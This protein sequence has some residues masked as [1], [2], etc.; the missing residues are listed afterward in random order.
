MPDPGMRARLRERR[1]LDAPGHADAAEV[2]AHEVDDHHVLGAVL[3]RCRE[4]LAFGRRRDRVR[5]PRPRA[6]DRRAAHAL[7][8]SLEEQ[9]RRQARDHPPPPADAP[10]RPPRNAARSGASAA[11]AWANRSTAPAVEGR[12]Q[13]QREVRLIEV[14]G[15]DPLAAGATA[16]AC[17]AGDGLRPPGLGTHRTGRLDTCLQ[18]AAQ[19]L[20][21]CS[22]A[23]AR[24]GV[25]SASNHHC[26]A[27]SRRSR[28][29]YQASAKG[30]CA[31]PRRR[32]R[33]QGLQPAAES[34]AELADPAPAD[35]PRRRVVRPRPGVGEHGER[36]VLLVGEAQRL[37]ARPAPVLPPS[38]R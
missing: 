22:I 37:R 35:E 33:R 23:S 11:V 10:G 16:R 25:Q 1:D 15:G 27:A 30:G 36:V 19:Q 2:V 21:R 6:L 3:A 31:L 8:T 12:A 14:A 7:A 38:A 5:R 28:W 13:P 24:S 26:P 29:S 20:S 32:R 18:P 9:L 17:P 4:R 34:V